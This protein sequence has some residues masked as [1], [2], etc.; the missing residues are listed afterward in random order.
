ME[1]YISPQSGQFYIFFGKSMV[2]CNRLEIKVISTLIKGSYMSDK[3]TVN[4]CNAVFGVHKI[5]TTVLRMRGIKIR[6]VS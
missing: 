6:P 4:S 1:F 5:R 3:C 2:V